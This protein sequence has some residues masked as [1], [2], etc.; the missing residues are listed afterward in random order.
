MGK[1]KIQPS[2]LFTDQ[3]EEQIQQQVQAHDKDLILY[4]HP[5]VYAYAS[6][7]WFNSIKAKWRRQYGVR[8][9]EDQSLGMLQTRFSEKSDK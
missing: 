4:V 3:V 8:L 2:I 5:Y 9:M 7:G 1:G 6:R